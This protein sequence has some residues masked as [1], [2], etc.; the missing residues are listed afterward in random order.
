MRFKR[1][2]QDMTRDAVDP[3][4]KTA[5]MITKVYDK[6]LELESSDAWQKSGDKS[7][8]EVLLNLYQEQFGE[9]MRK[10]VEDANKRLKEL[11]DDTGLDESINFN[12]I[13]GVEELSI[14]FN[15]DDG[16]EEGEE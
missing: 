9:S 5:T 8:Q 13:E 15:E 10:S 11:G 12:D 7:S 1:L 4:L 14:N 2:D 16:N 6:I 3:L